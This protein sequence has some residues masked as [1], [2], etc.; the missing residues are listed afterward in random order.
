MYFLPLLKEKLTIF[1]SKKDSCLFCSQSG[2]DC[3]G[4]CATIQL[5]D[6]FGVVRPRE[7]CGRGTVACLPI[8]MN[9]EPEQIK[10]HGEDASGPAGKQLT[11]GE[12]AEVLGVDAFTIFSLIQRGRIS[13]ARSPS[14][15]TTIPETELDRLTEKKG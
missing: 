8:F 9:E 15:E 6:E 14:G 12:A 5:D 1:Y 2:T 11:T 13:P 3:W 7:Q 4:H 10:L